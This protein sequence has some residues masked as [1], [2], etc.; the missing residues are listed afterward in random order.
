MDQQA[1]VSELAKLRPS[2]TFLSV[3]GYRNEHSEVADFSI[4][5]HISYENAL[6]RSLLALES[7][8]PVDDLEAVAKREL[9]DGYQ[10]SLTKMAVTPVEE[11]DDAYTR[12]FDEN[13]NYIKG[14]KLHTATSTLHLY[15][16]LNSKRVLVPGQYKPSNKRALT[17]AKDK[18]RKMCPVDRFR[19]FKLDPN[20][21][22]RISV[23][24]LVFLPLDTDV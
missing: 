23:E 8:V 13:G 7:H 24:N 12:F 19:Q 10:K 17:I 9:M 11:I 22:E 2:S 20:R 3:M 4:V 16:L 5:F 18:L 14:V 21:L 15:G 6:K 1:F